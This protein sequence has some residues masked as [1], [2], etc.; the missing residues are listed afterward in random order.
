MAGMPLSGVRV[1]GDGEELPQ[2][3]RVALEDAGVLRA[4]AQC[5]ARNRHDVEAPWNS[6]GP[7]AAPEELAR[8]AVRRLVDPVTSGVA[9]VGGLRLYL[10]AA[11]DLNPGPSRIHVSAWDADAEVWRLV[12]ELPLPGA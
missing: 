5:F 3:V 12:G 10:T 4:L 11:S 1:A 6:G 8:A 7:R 9:D 2:A